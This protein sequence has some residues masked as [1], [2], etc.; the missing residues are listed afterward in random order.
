MKERGGAGN[1]F[2][3]G[4]L[5]DHIRPNPCRT[6]ANHSLLTTRI[7]Q[8]YANMEFVDSDSCASWLTCKVMSENLTVLIKD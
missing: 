3:A 6:C 7:Q 2:S 1:D 5:S 4:S 8:T